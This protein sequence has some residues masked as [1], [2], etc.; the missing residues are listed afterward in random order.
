MSEYETVVSVKKKKWNRIEKTKCK[1]KKILEAGK[2]VVQ[3]KTENRE[4]P[5][6]TA[7]I[8]SKF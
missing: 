4:S 1:M 7:E 6:L 3:H 2:S 5:N 8:I